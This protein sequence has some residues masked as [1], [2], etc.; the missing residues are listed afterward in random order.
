MPPARRLVSLQTGQNGNASL[1]RRLPHLSTASKRS[2]RSPWPYI[3]RVLSVAISIH[4]C[5]ESFITTTQCVIL[6]N[7][8]ANGQRS[9]PEKIESEFVLQIPELGSHRGLLFKRTQ[10]DAARRAPGCFDT[11]DVLLY[12][13][14]VILTTVPW[15]TYK[16]RWSWRWMTRETSSEHSAAETSYEVS[17]LRFG[18]VWPF[19]LRG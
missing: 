17:G 2:A 14:I 7:R 13:I 19:T 1:G 11:C 12:F 6:K 9:C 5:E 18:C 16:Q 8:R 4:V 3:F 15:D 10:D